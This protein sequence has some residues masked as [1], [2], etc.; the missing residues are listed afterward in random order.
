MKKFVFSLQ[1]VLE[2][3]EYEEDK[4]KLELGK[5][6]AEL[7]RIKRLLQEVAQNRVKANLSR[8]DTTDVIVLMN[9][10]NYII[11]LDAKKEKLLEELIMAQMF[12][13]EKR[14]LYTKAMQDREVLSKLKEKQLSE[15]K[16]EVLK[17]EENALDD[18]VKNSEL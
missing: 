17:E 18:I 10:E 4:A 15:Y 8:K 9:I 6:V 3:R 13:E 11:G 5:A 12:F 14:D 7:E 1:K 16:K 2:L